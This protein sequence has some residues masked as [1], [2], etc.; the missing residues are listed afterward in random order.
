[1]KN[2]RAYRLSVSCAALAVS[3]MALA[4]APDPRL[5][6]VIYDADEIF[7]LAA[8]V[9]YQIDVEFEAGERFVGLGAGDVEGVTFAAQANHL[10]LKPKA[11]GTRTN[12]TVL[13]NRR[14][15]HF[16]YRTS[17]GAPDPSGADVLYVLRFLY[18]DA[19]T[20]RASRPAESAPLPIEAPAD[21]PRNNDY[22]YCGREELAPLSAWDDGVQTHLR[23]DPRR[24]LPA[25]FVRNDDGSESLLNFH[26]ANGELIAHQ[27]AR[28]F[29]VRRG[30]LVGCIVNRGFVGSVGRPSSGT[31][32]PEVER[33]TREAPD[34]L[35]R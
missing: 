17:A 20:P 5:R 27:L 3:L 24:E 14:A 18:A 15:Y 32:T 9:G 13:T 1:V 33:R 7:R 21:Q 23:F 6:T 28:R 35:D 22:W 34:A 30:G 8:Y 2:T 29:I 12:L 10:F 11:A 4:A 25:V 31:L 26:I 19:A 16:D